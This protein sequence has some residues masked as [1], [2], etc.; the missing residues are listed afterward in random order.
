M[1]AMPPPIVDADWI[2]AHRE[3]PIV[4]CD[5]RSTM[6]SATPRAEFDR[7][8]LPGTVF[9]SL[10]DDLSAPAGPVVGRHPLPTVD[11]FAATLDR[12]GIGDDDVVL[13]F[14]DRR[15]AFA[16]RLVWMLRTLGHPAALA[17]LVN[18]S[19]LSA[20]IGSRDRKETPTG[21]AARVVRDWPAEAVV[22][23]DRVV[24]HIGAGGVVVD[25][26]E[27]ARYAGEVEPIDAVA[28]HVPGAVNVPFAGNIGDDGHFLATDE[29]AARFA[30]AG[31][32]GDAIVYC[33]SG[34]TA[35]HNALAI[36]HAGRGRPAVYV[37]S[38]SGW[39]TD[40]TRPVATGPE[41]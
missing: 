12:L 20:A 29:L 33:G 36:E 6:A 32:D 2:D 34:V 18:K 35:C 17:D 38:W 19:Q 31:A 16:A 24:A 28:G 26:R 37:A 8:H 25:S 30:A 41:P 21:R 10:E 4:W 13:A 7:E 23:A 39:S 9:V 15:G 5:V 1:P 14:D 22:D 11:D 40:P 3:L 27:A